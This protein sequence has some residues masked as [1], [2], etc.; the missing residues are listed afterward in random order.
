M[1]MPG[2]NG[3]MSVYDFLLARKKL[4]LMWGFFVIKIMQ[5]PA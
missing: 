4:R 1:V 5:I 2:A 3:P